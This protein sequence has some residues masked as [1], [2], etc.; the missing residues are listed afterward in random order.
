MVQVPV[1]KQVNLSPGSMK[2]LEYN[3]GSIHLR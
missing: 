1:V 3:Q 2:Y